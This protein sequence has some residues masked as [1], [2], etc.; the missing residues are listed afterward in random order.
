MTL[1]V[2]VKLDCISLG[3]ADWVECPSTDFMITIPGDKARSSGV[4]G[5][6][7]KLSGCKPEICTHVPQSKFEFVHELKIK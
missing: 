1:T 7:N 3:H 2:A 4:A 6:Q 5:C